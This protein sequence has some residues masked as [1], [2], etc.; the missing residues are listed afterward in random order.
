MRTKS[1]P[2]TTKPRTKEQAEHEAKDQHEIRGIVE[3]IIEEVEKEA[4]EE[5][6]FDFAGYEYAEVQNALP[7]E[8]IQTEP[9]DEDEDEVSFKSV[10]NKRLYV[11]DEGKPVLLQCAQQAKVQAFVEPNGSY[12]GSKYFQNKNAAAKDEEANRKR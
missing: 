3:E 2:R 9:I 5:D 4:F 6:F 7:E 12:N 8:P 1:K 10:L 11:L